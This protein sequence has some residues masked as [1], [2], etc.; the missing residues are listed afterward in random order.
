MVQK[1]P[2]LVDLK[3]CF[4]KMSLLSLS[5]ASIRPRTGPRKFDQPTA[6][7]PGPPS[8]HVSSHG[9]DA[10][11]GRVVREVQVEDD[12]FHGA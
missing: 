5:E 6:S 8:R 12:V 1:S 10:L 11:D 7:Y 9:H 4:F 2:D 3:E